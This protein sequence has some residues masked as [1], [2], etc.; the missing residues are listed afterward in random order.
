[1]W[2]EDRWNRKVKELRQTKTMMPRIKEQN[3]QSAYRDF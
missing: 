2:R 3:T 1:M